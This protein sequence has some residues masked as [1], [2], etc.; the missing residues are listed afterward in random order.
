MPVISFTEDD[1]LQASGKWIPDLV[2]HENAD[3][4]DGGRCGLLPELSLPPDAYA[5]YVERNGERQVPLHSH[6]VLSRKVPNARRYAYP[7]PKT[8]FPK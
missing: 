7:I 1:L 2:A 4:C 6:L 3:S 8:G 5:E